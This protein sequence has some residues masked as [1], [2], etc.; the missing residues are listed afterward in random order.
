MR[1]L[2][3]RASVSVCV[4][5]YERMRVRACVY[6]RALHACANACVCMC[7]RMWLSVRMCMCAYVCAGECACL[8]AGFARL[9]SV[10]LFVFF[11]CLLAHEGI[12]SLAHLACASSWSPEYARLRLVMCWLVCQTVLAC[13]LDVMECADLFPCFTRS[14]TISILYRAPEGPP[15][16]YV[17]GTR[18]ASSGYVERFWLSKGPVLR[19]PSWNRSF[20]NFFWTGTRRANACF[21]A[22]H[23]GPL[24][25][26]R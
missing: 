5:V 3:M 2:C 19:R 6:A 20:I 25:K 16:D 24:A 10:L 18:R 14:D 8:R 17:D 1:M 22:A 23:G 7:E 9:R 4:C 11:A 13:A 21:R 12:C 26:K 15:L